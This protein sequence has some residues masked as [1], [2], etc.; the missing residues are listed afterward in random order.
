MRQIFCDCTSENEPPSTVKSWAKTATR[1]P[2]IL[3]KPE[4]TPSPGKR[5]LGHPEVADVV[6]GERA[7]LLERALVE[8]HREPLARGELALGVLVGHA[9]RAAALQ[10]P[11]AHLAQSP[12]V[13]AHGVS[14]SRGTSPPGHRA[15]TTGPERN[16][17][18]GS[19]PRAG[20]TLRSLPGTRQAQSLAP[21]T[22]PAS[23]GT[24]SAGTAQ[25]SGWARRT[26][27][28][29]RPQ[30]SRSMAN[31]SPASVQTTSLTGAAPAAISRER[32]AATIG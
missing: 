25:T 4:T 3:P 11:L 16:E 9:L 1:R 12:E 23:S 26:S 24:A 32:S 22:A 15:P 5:L 18:R 2:L 8:Q 27:C 29:A 14:A 21:V 30:G 20:F 19:G 13:V 7:D 28:R 10:S 6:G 31:V 17:P